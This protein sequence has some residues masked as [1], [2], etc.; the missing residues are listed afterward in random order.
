MKRLVQRLNRSLPF[1]AWGLGHED[2][3]RARA[4]RHWINTQRWHRFPLF[5]RWAWKLCLRGLWLL[6]CP[7]RTWRLAAMLRL[8]GKPTHRWR[9]VANGW[10]Y[11][12]KP[13]EELAPALQFGQMPALEVGHLRDNHWLMLWPLLGQR[14]SLLLAQDKLALAEKLASMGLPV[15]HLI[16]ELP[17]G[18]LVGL[19]DLLGTE[20]QKL[21]IKPRHGNRAEGAMSLRRLATDRW[22]VNEDSMWSDTTLLQRLTQ[23]AAADSML[24][25]PCLKPARDTLDL[26]PQV[27][28]L[29]RITTAHSPDGQA[30]VHSSYLRIQVP[31]QHASVRL[32]NMFVVPI[33]P[34]SGLME[35]GFRLS[36]PERRF[37]A[38]PWNVAPIAG[39]TIPRYQ[40]A[41]A[42]VLAASRAL[43]GV[44]VLGWDVLLTDCGP[45]ILET[46][47]GLSWRL[48]H[49]RHAITG[50][51]SALPALIERWLAA[52]SS[53]LALA[54]DVER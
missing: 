41:E 52:P 53:S 36:E 10:L 45:V 21:F 44:P 5:S 28:L 49:L 25:Q 24:L 17:K 30:F 43:P 33:E 34:G 13:V 12:H 3:S 20:P 4:I 1:D 2:D 6:W 7:Y 16:K 54:T 46:N 27:P 37:E 15:P 31:H 26:S 48:M 38:V 35:F 22:R 40:E 39:R 50:A 29:L 11:A 32:E 42:M 9:A 18:C 19:H 51:K 47:T 23:L 14:T 8:M